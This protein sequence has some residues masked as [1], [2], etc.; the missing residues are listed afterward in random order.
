VQLSHTS[1]NEEV[2][3]YTGALP[4]HRLEELLEVESL[5]TESERFYK[6]TVNISDI[7]SEIEDLIRELHKENS[8]ELEYAVDKLN[9]IWSRME[10]D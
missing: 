6:T 5:Y 8:A 10:E 9:S 4:P 1:T 7:R 3:K 2:F